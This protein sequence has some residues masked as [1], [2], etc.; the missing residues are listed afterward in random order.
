MSVKVLIGYIP[1]ELDLQDSKVL[2]RLKETTR[3]RGQLLSK[4]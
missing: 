3:S 1:R 4:A 2:T